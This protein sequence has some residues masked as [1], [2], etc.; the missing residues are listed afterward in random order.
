MSKV[1]LEVMSVSGHDVYEYGPE[2]DD[3]IVEMVADKIDK[4][5]I[6]Y[7]REGETGD[8]KVL[9]RSG[10][11]LN[12]KDVKKKLDKVRYAMLDK[13]EGSDEPIRIKKKVLAPPVRGG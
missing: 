6:L 2:S 9:I 1:E 11:T 3:D 12:E 5:W 7:G 10:E 4:G 13:Q 8:M